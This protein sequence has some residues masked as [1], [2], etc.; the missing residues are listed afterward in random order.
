M[1]VQAVEGLLGLVTKE[2][3][4]VADSYY[5]EECRS[6]GTYCCRCHSPRPAISL[7]DT[8]M[9]SALAVVMTAAV[10]LMMRCD[11]LQNHGEF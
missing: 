7:E 2:A 4:A 3:V 11:D 6:S 8:M 1:E 5:V 9:Q 10:V